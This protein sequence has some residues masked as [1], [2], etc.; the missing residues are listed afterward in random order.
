GDWLMRVLGESEEERTRRPLARDIA[1]I[2][3]DC[4]ERLLRWLQ[5]ERWY[6][7]RNVVHILGWIGG[8]RIAGHLHAALHHSDPRVRREVVATLGTVSPETSRPILLGMLPVERGRLFTLVV[9]QLT[10]ASDPVVAQ[11]L[12]ELLRDDRFLRR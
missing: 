4:P 6:V 3:A 8:D 9:Q 11:R 5:D 7:V 10:V 12:L 2:V 1:T